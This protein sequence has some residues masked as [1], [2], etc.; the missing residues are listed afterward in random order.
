MATQILHRDACR[1][2]K[3]RD[4]TLLNICVRDSDKQY[5]DNQLHDHIINNI[6]NLSHPWF[7]IAAQWSEP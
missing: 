6:E 1:W 7:K 2:T 4:L 5:H 3:D